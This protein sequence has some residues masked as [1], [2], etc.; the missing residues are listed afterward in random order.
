MRPVVVLACALLLS[1]CA[2]GTDA[3]LTAQDAK[4]ALAAKDQAVNTLA[5]A[6]LTAITTAAQAW[7]AGNGSMTG[8]ADDLRANNPSAAIAA[9]VLTDAQASVR[10]GAGS[11]LTATLPAGQPT[12]TAC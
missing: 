9:V 4:S 11:C 2:A 1:G 7:L 6:Q 12:T 10:V 3:A 5:T 8:F